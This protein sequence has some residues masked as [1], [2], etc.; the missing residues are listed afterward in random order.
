MEKNRVLT[1]DELLALPEG[2]RAYGEERD[3]FVI[4]SDLYTNAG[5]LMQSDTQ[6]F[7]DL[8]EPDW[9]KDG[10][11]KRVDVRFWALPQ[12]P[13]PDELASNPWP[14]TKEE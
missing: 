1:L 11:F 12:P 8:A 9:D 4:H 2:A 3:G 5:G 14:D 10:S 7:Y 6:G 13:T